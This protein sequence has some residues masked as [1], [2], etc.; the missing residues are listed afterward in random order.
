MTEIQKVLVVAAHPD[1][2]VLGCGGA[3]T[4]LG[5]DGAEVYIGFLGEGLTSRYDLREETDSS[6]LDELRRNSR[7]AADLLGAKDLFHYD[8]PDNRFDTVPLL[9]LVKTVENLVTELEPQVIYTHHG[10]DL[11]IDHALTFRAVMTA[12]RP[13]GDSIV[14]KLYTFETP[15]S[16]DWAFGN[17]KGVFNPNVFVDVSSVLETKIKA[18][19]CYKSEVRAFPHPRSPKA[20]RAVGERWGSVAGVLAAEAFQLIRSIR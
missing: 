16:T 5:Q 9:S 13:M 7:Q 20:L 6:L 11:N 12:A 3:I 19:Q 14:K 10:G 8:F 15:S 4:R 17:I 1:D 2:E 18:M